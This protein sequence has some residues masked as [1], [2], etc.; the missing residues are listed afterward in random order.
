VY[1]CEGRERKSERVDNRERRRVRERERER[2]RERDK[3]RE[4]T[5][6]H[7]HARIQLFKL[8]GATLLAPAPVVVWWVRE[9][10][11]TLGTLFW[12]EAGAEGGDTPR[13]RVEGQSLPLHLMTEMCLGKQSPA[14]QGVGSSFADP[15]TCFTLF[16]GDSTLDLEA[17]SKQMR[18]DWM[19]EI[20]QLLMHGGLKSKR[21][22]NGAS[23]SN[24]NK[25]IT[26]T[27]NDKGDNSDTATLDEPRKMGEAARAGVA[28]LAKGGIFDRYVVEQSGATSITEVRMIYVCED[29]TTPGRYDHTPVTPL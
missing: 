8:H 21:L 10:G 9:E 18:T 22:E 17:G 20:H 19:D 6:T 5:K 23:N 3:K 25:L 4:I 13:E 7:T 12:S 28:L 29:P 27:E 2:E 16:R 26:I 15:N 24:S 14:F 11:G 1:V